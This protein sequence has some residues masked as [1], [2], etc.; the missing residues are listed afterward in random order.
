MNQGKHVLLVGAFT[1]AL[2]AWSGC[3]TVIHQSQAYYSDFEDSAAEEPLDSTTDQTTEGESEKTVI[4]QRY[5]ESPWYIPYPWISFAP[6]Y[7][8]VYDP[9]WYGVG[10]PYY[11]YYWYGCRYPT[12]YIPPHVPGYP[13]RDSRRDFG[14]RGSV[15]NATSHASSRSVTSR[16]PVLSKPRYRTAAAGVSV[17]NDKKSSLGGNQDVRGGGQESRSKETARGNSG[18]RNYRGE[19]GSSRSGQTRDADRGGQRNYRGGSQGE[20][21]R[22]SGN[23]RSGE[24]RSERSGRRSR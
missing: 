20:R 3:Y 17:E 8:A 1:F 16:R 9:Y 14:L 15:V 11:D 10:Y 21:S 4:I 12:G 2:F 22:G 24:S 23:S 13:T 5:Y 6:G 7:V 18:S 19:S